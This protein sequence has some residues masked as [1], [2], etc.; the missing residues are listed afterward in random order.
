MTDQDQPVA[1]N[2]A[3]AGPSTPARVRWLYPALAVTGIA[4]GIFIIVAGIYVFFVQPNASY[5]AK[6]DCCTSMEGDMKKMMADMKTQMQQAPNMTSMPNMPP[7]PG[8]SPMPSMP[9]MSQTPST[10]PPSR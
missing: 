4:V 8:M 2:P 10:P 6:Q 5:P 9:S 1:D 3:A 7:M